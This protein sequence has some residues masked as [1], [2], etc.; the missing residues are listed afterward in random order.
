MANVLVTVGKDIEVGASDLL[1]W[2]T[3]GEKLVEKASP[4]VLSALGVLAAGVEKCLTD[5]VNAAQNPLAAL[6]EAPAEISDIKQVW[7][8]VKQFLASFGVKV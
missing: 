5:A 6:V 7:P 4:G 3:G 8:E 2:V 1:R